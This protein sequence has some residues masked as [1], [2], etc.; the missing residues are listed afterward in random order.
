MERYF[1]GNNSGYGF[2]NLYE[3]ELKSTNKTVLLKGGSG[4]GKSSLLKKI[5][6]KAKAMGL[7]YELWFCS[8]DPQ[9][10]DGIYLKDKKAAVV[11]ATAPH[12]SGVDIPVIKDV[13]FDLAQ[14]LDE[15]KLKGARQDIEKYIKCKKQHFMRVYQHLKSA[16]CH[17]YNQFEIEKQGVD[18]DKIRAYA[19]S[20]ARDMK[21]VTDKNRSLFA[22]AI[23]PVGESEYFDH[24]RGKKAVLVKGCAYAKKVFFDEISKLRK[25]LTL[26]L[27]PLDPKTCEG[28]VCGDVAYVENVG[29]FANDSI[30]DLGVFGERFDKDDSIEESNNVIMQ[31]A[32]AVERLNKAREAHMKVESIF[33]PAMDFSNNEKMLDKI[34]E[35]IFG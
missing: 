5:A 8:G 11:D 17:L 22:R 23:C 20:I 13:I 4:T 32:F 7:D 27:S 34:N 29:H 6:K 9:S 35:F 18:E 24:L 31:T 26:F 16:L 14:S 12:A 21:P 1:L 2:F 15:S 10:L 25:G 19:S 33:V 30:V 3:N 28:I